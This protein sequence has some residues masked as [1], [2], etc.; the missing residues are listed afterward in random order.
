MNSVSTSTSPLQSSRDGFGNATITT[1]ELFQNTFIELLYFEALLCLPG[2][3]SENT[4]YSYALTRN[5]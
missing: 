4:K 5:E 2:F 1:Y 3:T